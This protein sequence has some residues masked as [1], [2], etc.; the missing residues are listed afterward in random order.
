[1]YCHL[2][3]SLFEINQ[4]FEPRPTGANYRYVYFLAED[5]AAVCVPAVAVVAAWRR[6]GSSLPEGLGEQGGEGGDGAV[7]LRGRPLP[8]QEP[9]LQGGVVQAAPAAG[10]HYSCALSLVHVI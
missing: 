10:L 4:L 1:M 9:G 5:A 7:A 6:H 8:R 3:C 2:L